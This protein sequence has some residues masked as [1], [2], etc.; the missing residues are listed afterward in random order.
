MK[1]IILMF[2]VVFCLGG[3][4]SEKESNSVD[5]GT[6]KDE[7]TIP[8][9]YELI[10]KDDFLEDEPVEEEPEETLKRADTVILS[11]KV[12]GVP[13]STVIKLIGLT[14]GKGSVSVNRSARVNKDGVYT[15]KNVLT[16]SY[17]VSIYNLIDS[18]LFASEFIDITDMTTSKTV[19]L[20]AINTSDRGIL[21]GTIKRGERAVVKFVRSDG[22][23]FHTLAKKGGGYKIVLPAGNYS[24][25]AVAFRWEEGLLRD[26]DLDGV[27]TIQV[28][29]KSNLKTQ[30]NFKTGRIYQIIVVQDV[31]DE[32]LDKVLNSFNSPYWA[33]KVITSNDFM[34]G[35]YGGLFIF[36]SSQ[37]ESFYENIK[38]FDFK[39]EQM[40][41]DYLFLKGNYKNTFRF[42]TVFVNSKV[43]TE[44]VGHLFSN[45]KGESDYY[46]TT[47]TAYAC[48][49]SKSVDGKG[50]F[51]EYNTSDNVSTFIGF[52][53]YDTLR[54]IIKL[55]GEKTRD[56]SVLN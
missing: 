35:P 46:I 15:F 47:K 43:N 40:S 48:V 24:V 31:K 38:T 3:C 16:G 9:G 17:T 5:T 30:R 19:N 41:D 37:P 18:T 42:D 56:F 22:V 7:I 32:L 8:A 33:L 54:N 10:T 1:K 12:E 20:K 52:D 53:D 23:V 13:Q 26:S 6:E 49:Y 29:V 51:I 50:T 25:Y 2:L 21:Y 39:K 55:R 14:Y 27:G 34:S 36:A 45:Y 4:F 28:E 11:G 44:G